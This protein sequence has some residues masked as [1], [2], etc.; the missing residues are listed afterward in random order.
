MDN[1]IR[2]LL[3]RAARACGIGYF[4]ADLHC[5][6]GGQYGEF[7]WKSD[8]G[9]IWNPLES[10]ADRARMEDALMID[11]TQ[12]P[13][14]VAVSCIKLGEL[15]GATEFL[16][17]HAGSREAAH[18]MASLRVAAMLAGDGECQ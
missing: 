7:I 6:R 2:E 12:W 14:R 1:D 11:I 18:S 9:G 5:R 15:V 17:D 3:E 10:I 8:G 16:S 13:D 4:I